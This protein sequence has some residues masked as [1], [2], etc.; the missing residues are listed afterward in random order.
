MAESTDGRGEKSKISA[1]DL[2]DSGWSEE[3]LEDSIPA[4]RVRVD[5]LQ[6]QADTEKL[7]TM[8]SLEKEKQ[9]LESMEDRLIKDLLKKSRKIKE[10]E[11]EEDELKEKNI[12]QHAKFKKLTKNARIQQRKK[13]TAAIKTAKK[14]M[15]PLL[16]Q[17]RIAI[18]KQG[19]WVRV[20]QL[21]SEKDRAVERL[22]TL[23]T[24]FKE[25][26]GK[27]WSDVRDEGPILLTSNK[28]RGE[29]VREELKQRLKDLSEQKIIR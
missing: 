16:V 18:I 22:E 12:A 27:E 3:D 5:N 29:E 13:K 10:Y 14:I 2:S 6:S 7:R 28:V 24:S 15:K 19:A 25:V 26:T 17:L 21:E 9:T 11:K 23:R 8:K 4:Q 20:Q 1:A